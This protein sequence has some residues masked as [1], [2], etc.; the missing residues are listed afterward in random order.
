MGATGR[1]GREVLLQL[2][3]RADVS[4]RAAARSPAHLPELNVKVP[5]VDVDYTRTDV[6]EAALRGAD[7]MYWVTPGGVDQLRYTR[8]MI[9][10]ALRAG[11]QHIVKVGTLDPNIAPITGTDRQCGESERII[12]ESGI[13][14][15]FLRCSFYDQMFIMG[16]D[17]LRS[18]STFISV[19]DGKTGWLDC[20]DIGAVAAKVIAE[21]GH[22]GKVYNLTGPQVLGFDDLQKILERVAGRPVHF[23]RITTDMITQM[24]AHESAECIEARLGCLTK[25]SGGFIAYTTDDVR[26]L[27]G[28]SA[29]SFEVFAR[30]HARQ[31]FEDDMPPEVPGAR[32]VELSA[33]R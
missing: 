8:T 32:A 10:A 23:I 24:F 25:L 5:V 26:K 33:G 20:R 11:I 4:V 13:A 12:A 9:E 18:G 21:G 27:L 28:R 14:Y 1:T 22:A 7:R 19:S 16:A 29:T 15:T 30:D 2:V 3:Q 17:G 31:L 6:L